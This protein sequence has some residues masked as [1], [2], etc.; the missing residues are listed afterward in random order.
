MDNVYV[1]EGKTSTEAIEK[2]LMTIP[3]LAFEIPLLGSLAN[4]LGIFFGA[5]VA[6]II[7]AIAIH[8]IE[9]QV[10][11][12]LRRDNLDERIIKGNEILKLQYQA[13][14][15]GEIKLDR[16]K[17]TVIN[18]IRNRHFAAVQEMANSI[19]NIRANCA[20]DQR[21]QDDFDACDKL[22]NE[23]KD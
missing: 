1:F 18:D 3:V 17:N 8:L 11:N 13:Q 4:I 20:I 6:G 21:T 7:G 12:I 14:R 19:D 16:T 22:L 15:V 5:V 10:E 9:K 2:G 23:L